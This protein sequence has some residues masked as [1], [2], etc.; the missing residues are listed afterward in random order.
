MRLILYKV[1]LNFIYKFILLYFIFFDESQPNAF[2]LLFYFQV[3]S[4]INCHSLW[5]QLSTVCSYTT[6]MAHY[7]VPGCSRPQPASDSGVRDGRSN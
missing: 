1:S 5:G 7:A 3:K 2:Y 6:E 4:G